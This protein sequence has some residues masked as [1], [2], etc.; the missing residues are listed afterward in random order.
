MKFDENTRLW[1]VTHTKEFKP[2]AKY[3]LNPR[4]HRHFMEIYR[5]RQLKPFYP[6]DTSV[7]LSSFNLMLER[8]QKGERIFQDFG[9]DVG[10]FSFVIGENKPFV[11]V[12]PGGA[13]GDVCNFTEGFP[14]AARL[15][16]LGYNAFVG[17]YRIGKK[18]LFPNPQEDVSKILAYIFSHAKEW[19]VSTEDYAMMGFS[20]GGQL[21]ASFA[22]KNAGYPIYGCKAPSTLMLA[23][24]AIHMGTYMD[25]KIR[26]RIFGEHY[27]D[28]A[29]FDQYSVEKHIDIDY[30]R[31]FVWQCDQDNVVPYEN[32]LLLVEALK[33]N[34][35]E[36]SH[37]EVKG[38][39]HGLGLGVGSV[40]EGWLEKAVSFWQKDKTKA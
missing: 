21:A 28:S 16:E 35:V 33:A 1:T 3:L 2:F 36:Y 40:A 30:P 27:N 5:F 26:K 8:C 18:A 15:N 22:T 31:T 32:T 24:P 13:Y 14:V 29:V 23:Y 34:G 4:K 17:Q 6:F 20:A 10:L 38:E 37:L 25:R 7:F 9:E 11:L 39:T 19:N 12:L